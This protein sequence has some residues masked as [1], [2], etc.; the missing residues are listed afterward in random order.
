MQTTWSNPDKR[1]EHYARMLLIDFGPAFNTRLIANIPWIGHLPVQMEPEL[2]D[3]QTA[4]AGH[5]RDSEHSLKNPSCMTVWPYM[6]STL[7]SRWLMT[8]PLPLPL[9]EFDSSYSGVSVTIFS[10][11]VCQTQVEFGKWDGSEEHH[12]F[13]ASK[14]QLFS[15]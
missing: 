7:S 14:P 12:G 8:L 4:S 3:K 9:E 1:Q 5:F 10:L 13:S 11:N 15:L 2:P 6:T